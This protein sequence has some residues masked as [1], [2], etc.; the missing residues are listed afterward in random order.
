MPEIVD[1]HHLSWDK[2]RYVQLNDESTCMVCG[3]TQDNHWFART[4]P[5]KLLD[6]VSNIVDE[7]DRRL[8]E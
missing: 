6:E 5:K 7:Y 2:H 4:N 8:L 1:W 3:K